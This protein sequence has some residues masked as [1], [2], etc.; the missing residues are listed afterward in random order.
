MNSVLAWSIAFCWTLAL[1][2]PI[3]ALVLRPIAGARWTPLA[4]ALVVNLATHPLFS[5]WI[6][7]RGPGT[8]AIAAAELLIAAFESA[9]A[10]AAFRSHCTP[11]RALAAGALANLTSYFAGEWLLR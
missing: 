2:L 8:T 5:L 11:A 10:Y 9:L 3:Y 1:E 4:L 7:A 6:V